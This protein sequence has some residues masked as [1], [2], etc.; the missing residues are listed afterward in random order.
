MED[1]FEDFSVSSPFEALV[2]HI[3]DVCLL[4]LQLLIPLCLS[5]HAFFSRHFANGRCTQAHGLTI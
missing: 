4:S 3:Q 5:S 2:A 1:E